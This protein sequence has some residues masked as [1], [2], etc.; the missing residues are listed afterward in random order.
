MTRAT[1]ERVLEAAEREF[2]DHGFSVAKLADIAGRAGIRRSSLLYHFKS[3]EELYAA[4]V[5]RSFSRLRDA[6]L[7]AMQADGD[8]AGRL[9]MTAARYAEFLAA[10]PNLARLVLRELVEGQGPGAQILLEQVAPLVT[11]VERFIREAGA[12]VIR[13]GLPIRSAVLQLASDILLKSAAGPLRRPLWG[14]E[15]HTQTLARVVFIE[16]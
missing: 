1:P 16:E 14:D 11:I 15:D 3:K 4:T 9:D 8:F 6:L 7:A 2:A 5:E 12:G 13:S 10:E